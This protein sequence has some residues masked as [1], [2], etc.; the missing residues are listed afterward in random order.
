MRPNT[1]TVSEIER[2]VVA[3]GKLNSI[4]FPPLMACEE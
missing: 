1:E 2:K 3:N 4:W